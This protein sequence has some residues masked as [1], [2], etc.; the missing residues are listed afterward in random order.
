MVRPI[1]GEA[2]RPRL[3]L[4]ACSGRWIGEQMDG[5]VEGVAGSVGDGPGERVGGRVG[6]GMRGWMGGSVGRGWESGA[7]MSISQWLFRCFSHPLPFLEHCDCS[8]L[9]SRPKFC[10]S[11]AGAFSQKYDPSRPRVAC[12][13]LHSIFLPLSPMSTQNYACVRGGLASSHM[14]NVYRGREFG[15]AIFFV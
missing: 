11:R 15:L 1:F 9:C 6:D 3:L 5:G 12:Q 2:R 10:Q 8:G 13:L 14:L 4:G 7:S